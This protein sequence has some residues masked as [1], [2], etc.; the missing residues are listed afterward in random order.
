MFGTKITPGGGT[1]QDHESKLSSTTPDLDQPI[2]GD[3]D[4][5]NSPAS[6]LHIEERPQGEI[7]AQAPPEGGL[8]A[9]FAGK[10]KADKS[11]YAGC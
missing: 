1:M 6:S 10:L 4:S 5:T 11:K 2:H 9:W 8:V 3:A 7:A